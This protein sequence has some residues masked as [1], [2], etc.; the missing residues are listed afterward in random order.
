MGF[1]DKDRI[2]MWG[3][4]S[5]LINK[6]ISN[7]HST[8]DDTEHRYLRLR[9]T[10]DRCHNFEEMLHRHTLLCTITVYSKEVF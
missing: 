7:S 5:V 10:A 9:D 6:Y 3:W 1:I 8:N 4:V 2:G